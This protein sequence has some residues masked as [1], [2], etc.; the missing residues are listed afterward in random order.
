MP[1]YDQPGG[2]PE[3]RPDVV[4]AVLSALIDMDPAKLALLAGVGVTAA[5]RKQADDLFLASIVANAGY[6]ER[7]DEVWDVLITRQW[8]S[9]PTW[10]QLFE[11][12]TPERAARLGDLYDA[13]PNGARTEYDKR[14]GRPD[15]I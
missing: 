8:P 1:E 11:E 10:E 7:E 5:E 3:I 9:P 13:L 14:Y 6:R 15:Q 4:E 12:L 2:E